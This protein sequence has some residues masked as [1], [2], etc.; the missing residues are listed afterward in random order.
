MAQA[1]GRIQE[2]LQRCD[3]VI[4]IGDARAPR[5]SFPDYLDR[6]TEGKTKVFV[7]SK[8]DLADPVRFEAYRQELIAKGI[9]PFAFDLRDKAASKPM[10]RFLSNV[11]TQKDSRYIRLGF[12]LP[13]KYFMVLGIPN[14]GKSTFINALA[15]RNKA[16]VEN[17]PGKTRAEP[18]IHV[19][20]IGYLFD[21][22]GIL[23]PNY[24][25]KEVAARLALLGS[26]RMDIL[27]LIPLTDYLYER[28]RKDYAKEIHQRYQLDA[29]VS[30]EDF[31]EALAK[32]RGMLL[33]GN[34]PDTERARKTFLTEFRNGQI[35]R[36]SLDD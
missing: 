4:E 20:E 28:V 23:E 15:G 34:I 25:D 33:G 31:F 1:M 8:I 14:V 11:H 35:G 2:K 7:F 29:A 32:T 3:G 16:A 22:P 9:T 13:V 24:D 10:L 21:T 30:S 6:L 36:I 26:I 18:L 19:S 17:R 12:P 27:P 5:S